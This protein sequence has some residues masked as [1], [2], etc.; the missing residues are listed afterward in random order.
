[1]QLFA[2]CAGKSIS[3]DTCR[4]SLIPLGCS[5]W[6]FIQA[7]KQKYH[8]EKGCPLLPLLQPKRP[9]SEKRNTYSATSRTSKLQVS[10]LFHHGRFIFCTIW[11]RANVGLCSILRLDGSLNEPD[12][13]TILESVHRRASAKVHGTQ[14]SG[15][16]PREYSSSIIRVL[17]RRQSG[18]F[19]QSVQ[20]GDETE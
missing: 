10:R 19:M 9:N 6:T 4:I 2:G 5:A 11:R 18:A 7:L 8:R 16:M 14:H 1:M 17:Q 3:R 20:H 12:Q 15:M 13:R